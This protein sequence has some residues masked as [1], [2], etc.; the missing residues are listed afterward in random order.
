[1]GSDIKGIEGFYLTAVRMECE[2]ETAVLV[3]GATQANAWR[4]RH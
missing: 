4:W 3:I 2:P 1:M